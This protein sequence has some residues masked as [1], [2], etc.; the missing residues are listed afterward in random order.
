MSGPPIVAHRW[1]H[2][3]LARDM[4]RLPAPSVK[5]RSGHL[6][7]IIVPASRPASFLQPAMDLAAM[8][9]VLLVVLC[10]KQTQVGQVAQRIAKTPRAR[11]LIVPVPLEWRHDEIFPLQTSHWQ[12]KAAQR[13]RITDLSLKRNLGLLLA[14]LHGWHKV[15]FVDDDITLTKTENIGRLAGQLERHR[16][17][18]MVLREFPDN[19]VVCHAR[20]LAGGSQDVFVSGAVLGV[21]CDDLPLSYFP[22]I[23]NEDWFYFAKEAAAR[24]LPRVGQAEQAPFDPFAHPERAAWEEFG[25]LLA[26][27]L[28][29][30]FG[31]VDPD[32]SLVEHLSG[33]TR[34][35]WDRFIQVRHDVLTDTRMALIRELARRDFD[36]RITSALASLEAAEDVI[37]NS[38][39]ADLCVD[40]LDAWQQDLRDWQ[41]RTQ[42]VHSLRS[43]REA[44]D[45]LG[46]SGWQMAEFGRVDVGHLRGSQGPGGNGSASTAAARTDRVQVPAGAPR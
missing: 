8:L 6:D 10:S 30:L 38:I 41:S 44:M 2:A 1:S 13:G 17:A 26:E 15:A 9:D 40:F 5:S 43:T 35:F 22:D 21:R 16:T 7:A 18:G 46:L 11:C 28:F 29:A 24:D 20:R 19:S 3:H 4:S 25:D 27:G 31:E 37:T 32:L 14:R 45:Y 12:F 33:A 23:Y 42:R 39:T 36:R 34:R